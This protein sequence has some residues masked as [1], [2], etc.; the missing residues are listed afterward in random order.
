[1]RL[2]FVYSWGLSIEPSTISDNIRHKYNDGD[3]T[4]NWSLAEMG[5]QLVAYAVQKKGGFKIEFWD[6]G[7]DNLTTSREDRILSNPNI[8]NLILGINNDKDRVFQ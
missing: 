3:K 4:D 8:R 5:L 6:E 1:M 2:K 7:E